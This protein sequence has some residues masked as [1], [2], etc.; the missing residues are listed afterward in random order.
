M[1][2]PRF[3]V[4]GAAGMLGHALMDELAARSLLATGLDRRACDV[5]DADACLAVLAQLRP[6][7]AINCAAFTDVNG[8]ETQREAAMAVNGAGAG[9]V[10]RAC[11]KIGSRCLFVSTDY[12]FDGAKAEPYLE[13]D[14]VNPLNV[15]GGSKLEGERQT[16]A[17]CANSLVVRTSWLYGPYGRNFVQTILQ[18]AESGQPLGIVEDQTGAPTYTRDL[19]RVLCDVAVSKLTGVVHATNR[20]ACSWYQFAKSALDLAGLSSVQ[21]SPVK[22]SDYPTP[23]LRPANSRL[24]D[25]RLGTAG[26]PAMPT[27]ED[28]LR[29][30]LLET[31]RIS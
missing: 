3:V 2:M 20:G 10:A 1:E 7:V 13:T 27:W 21:L 18:R 25:T 23:A 12:V 9:N 28:G 15:Y 14:I 30:Y 26:I 11:E 6:A 16:L 17:G 19:A 31:G 4:F 22:T 29:R 24:T 8:A 5:T